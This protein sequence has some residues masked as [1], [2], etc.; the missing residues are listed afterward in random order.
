M[1]LSVSRT[2]ASQSINA[3][4][5]PRL[6][7]DAFSMA[8]FLLRVEFSVASILVDKVCFP[9]STAGSLCQNVDERCSKERDTSGH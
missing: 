3:L 6:R 5:Q 2:S 1:L 8:C 9:D 4:P 7:S